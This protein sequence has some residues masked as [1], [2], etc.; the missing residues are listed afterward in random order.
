[1]RVGFDLIIP[2]PASTGVHVNDLCVDAFQAFRPFVCQIMAGNVD[3]YGLLELIC[4]VGLQVAY[5]LFGFTC[6]HS[7]ANSSPWAS[8]LS[9]VFEKAAKNGIEFRLCLY[10]SNKLWPVYLACTCDKYRS[11]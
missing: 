9:Q 7:Q 11:V 10:G 4:Q 3:F 5:C 2:L 6:S 1:M 8:T